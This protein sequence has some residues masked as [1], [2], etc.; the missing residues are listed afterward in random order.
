MKQES[1]ELFLT[2]STS[3]QELLRLLPTLPAPA[4]LPKLSVTQELQVTP[5][6]PA[7]PLLT[8]TSSMCSQQL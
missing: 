2:S 3:S 7:S 1:H 6:W 4:H 8:C 5:L